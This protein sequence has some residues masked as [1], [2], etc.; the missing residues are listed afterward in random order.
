MRINELYGIKAI[1]PKKIHVGNMTDQRSGSPHFITSLMK[2]YGFTK[3]GDGAFAY[4]YSYKS[5]PNLV[6]KIFDSNNMGYPTF[7]K[8]CNQNPGNPCL[9]IFKGIPIKITDDVY[10]I[11]IEKLIPISDEE[12]KSLY[13]I[14][15][16]IRFD[17][18]PSYTEIDENALLYDTLKE[19]KFF[20][21]YRGR[22]MDWH[23]GNFMKRADNQIVITDPFS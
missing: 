20:G 13:T 15:N 22:W 7:I 17:G 18:N 10:M 11:R 8:F 1:K 3:I 4:V 2:K 6:V 14:I 19:L 21:K 12:W 23:Q 5:N 16:D 9:P